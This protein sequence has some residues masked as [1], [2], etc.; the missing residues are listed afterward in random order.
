MISTKFSSPTKPS[1][2]PD[3]KRSAFS[4]FSGSLNSDNKWMLEQMTNSS[5]NLYNQI[6]D[7]VPFLWNSSLIKNFNSD[8]NKPFLSNQSN[9]DSYHCSVNQTKNGFARYIFSKM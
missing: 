5:I 2:R 3:I 6:K 8:H 1:K 4:S 7:R 9:D